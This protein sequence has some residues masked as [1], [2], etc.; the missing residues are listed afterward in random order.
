MT[1][2]FNNETTTMDEVVWV[3]MRATGCDEEEAEI[4]AW[5]AHTYGKAPVHFASKEECETAALTIQTVGVA[6]EVVP[7][8]ND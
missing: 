1:V 7:E 4:E 2:I 8:W 5:E 6:T 3:L